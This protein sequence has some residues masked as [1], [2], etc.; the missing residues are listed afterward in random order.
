MGHR[1]RQPRWERLCQPY[2]QVFAQ[3]I[4]NISPL[5]PFSNC[6]NYLGGILYVGDQRAAKDST[7]LTRCPRSVIQWALLFA[8][9]CRLGVRAVVNCAPNLLNVH[10][11]KFSYLRFP[12]GKWKQH[13]GEDEHLLQA[14]LTTFL[15]VNWSTTKNSLLQFSVWKHLSQFVAGHLSAGESILIH[16]M[17]GAHRV[18][19]IIFFF[20]LLLVSLMYKCILLTTLR[21]GMAAVIALAFF[22]NKTLQNA[23]EE[24]TTGLGHKLHDHFWGSRETPLCQA[25]VFCRI[26]MLFKLCKNVKTGDYCLRHSGRDRPF[27]QL[28]T[29]PCSWSEPR[30]SF[31]GYNWHQL[32]NI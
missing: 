28:A 11:E 21:A 18:S 6:R 5:Q 20:F 4:P 12:I 9:P 25:D 22:N 19:F 7:L 14:F 16:C 27:A 15:Q 24:V 32:N 26:V 3:R 13:C 23:M 10:E 1:S 2:L 30:I 31:Q 8:K 17:A 29:F